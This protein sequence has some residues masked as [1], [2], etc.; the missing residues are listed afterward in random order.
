[1]GVTSRVGAAVAFEHL[2]ESE[3]EMG[4]IMQA[5]AARSSLSKNT[6]YQIVDA[7]KR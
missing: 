5:R 2:Q 3:G 4:V 6:I 1:M 7:D